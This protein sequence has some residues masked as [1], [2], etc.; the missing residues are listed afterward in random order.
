MIQNYPDEGLIRMLRLIVDNGGDGLT[1]AL[2]DNDLTPTLDTVL[3]DLTFPAGT[4][5]SKILKSVD[6]TLDQVAYHVG[7]IQ[8]AA[9]V[10]TNSSGSSKTVY[11]FAVYDQVNQLLIAAARFD[12]A[13]VIIAD[14]GMYNVLPILG[15]YCEIVVPEIDGGTF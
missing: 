6:F 4:W 12:A 9:I 5:A 14:G 10:F 7:T 8:G 1:W 13:P 3:A 11:G 2:F 15:D